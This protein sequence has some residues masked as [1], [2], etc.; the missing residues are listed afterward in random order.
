[1][2]R[3]LVSLGWRYASRWSEKKLINVALRH[4]VASVGIAANVNFQTQLRKCLFC[5]FC[6]FCVIYKNNRSE[7]L[8]AVL[9][10]CMCTLI[11]NQTEVY[12]L[13]QGIS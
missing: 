8:T 2:E 7:F 5:I 13:Y 10:Y 6:K 12:Y 11:N 3:L 9:D 1:M 4:L